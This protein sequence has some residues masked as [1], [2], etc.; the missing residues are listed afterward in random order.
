MRSVV[1]VILGILMLAIPGEASA[2]SSA[3]ASSV[4]PPV[5]QSLQ[6]PD[7]PMRYGRWIGAL[8]G[9][10]AAVVGANAWTGGAL[11]APAIGPVLSG[12]F[13]G[14]WLGVSAMNPLA[15]Q[16]FFQ[17]TSLIAYGV[18]GGVFGHWLGSR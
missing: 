4:P 6:D 5:V 17:T 9:T 13:G 10:T 12:I 11:L 18:A 1:L 7:T 15:A 16:G 14:S 3:P 8:A 2:Q